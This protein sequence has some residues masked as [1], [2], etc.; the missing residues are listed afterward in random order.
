MFG[1]I[2]LFGFL[3]RLDDGVSAG[4]SAVRVSSVGISTGE[5]VG[6]REGFDLGGLDGLDLDLSGLDGVV[7]QSGRE[8]K[9]SA[10]RDGDGGLDVLDNRQGLGVSVSLVHRVG[11]VASQTVRADDGAV[12]SRSADQHSGLAGGDAQSEDGQ[13]SKRVNKSIS[14]FCLQVVR[15]TYEFHVG[16]R[17]WVLRE[18]GCRRI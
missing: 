3:G 7:G 12:V 13:L 18:R 1:G 9:R 10:V 11:E 4:E 8:G 14:G 16:A 2:D 15:L 5:A 17:V 6:Q